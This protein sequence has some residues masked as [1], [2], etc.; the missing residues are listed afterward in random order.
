MLTVV[1]VPLA[2]FN[3]NMHVALYLNCSRL[4]TR[5]YRVYALF[6]QEYTKRKS[7]YKLGRVKSVFYA[8]I[9]LISFFKYTDRPSPVDWCFR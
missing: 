2:I 9:C 6:R 4:L 3:L 7:M 5:G 8:I 1:C